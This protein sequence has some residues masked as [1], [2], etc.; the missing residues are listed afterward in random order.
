M[1][2]LHFAALFC[3]FSAPALAQTSGPPAAPPAPEAA[4]APAAAP[5]APSVAD[6]V[7]AGFPKYDKD[8]SGELS[9]AEFGT[10]ITEAKAQSGGAAPDKKWLAEAFAKA[11][12]D[13]NKTISAGELTSFLS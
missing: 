11:D 12:A 3:A 9:K 7:A 13:K 6:T 4:P 1:N 2:K 5:A 10:W 8:G